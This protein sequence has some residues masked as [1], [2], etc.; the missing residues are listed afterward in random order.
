MLHARHD[1]VEFL[2]LYFEAKLALQ[3]WNLVSKGTFIRT[4]RFFSSSQVRGNIISIGN[5]GSHQP[6]SD[7]VPGILTLMTTTS[8]TRVYWLLNDT[9]SRVPVARDVVCNIT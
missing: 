7:E 9:F 5:V 8:F 3:L 1:K 4:K 2:L 6:I